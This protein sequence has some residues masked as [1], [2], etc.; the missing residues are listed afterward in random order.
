M[1]NQLRELAAAGQSVWLDNIKRSMFASG[2][3]QKFVDQGLRGQT[4]NPTIFEHAIGAGTDYDAQIKSLIATEHDPQLLFEALAIQDIRSACDVFAPVFKSTGGLDGYVSLEV[5]PTLAHDTNATTEAALRLWKEVDRPN[6]MIKIPGTPECLA[7]IRASIAAGVNINVTLL[8]SV[9]QYAAAANAYIDGLEDRVKAGG[10]IDTIA[11]VASV[12]VSRIDTAIDKML[13]ERIAK[14]EK[15][16]DLKGK[17]GIA[18]LKLTYQ[19][20]EQLFNGPRFAALKA[21]GA[22]V[23]R[24]LWASTSTKNP[25]YDDLMY[26]VNVVGTDTVN[27]MP[28]ATLDALLDHGVVRPDTIHED[29][30]GAKALV[31]DLAAK[32]ISLHDV[33]EQ[34]VADGVK[35]FAQSFKEMLDAIKG[36]HDALAAKVEA[37]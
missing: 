3:L 20:F 27:T 13:D 15:L 30:P 33:T 36:K 34:L 19:K 24:P 4:S 18:N 31:G 29:V 17:A 12:F 32:G 11:S 9:D 14:G 28:P 25:K 37:K 23:Q 22:K 7:S 35:S 16:E 5:S 10:A 1:G 26:V 6:V 2:E 8:F 21:K